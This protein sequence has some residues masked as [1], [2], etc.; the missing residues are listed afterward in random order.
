MN[1]VS[2]QVQLDKMVCSLF[3]QAKNVVEIRKRGQGKGTQK[4]HG[5]LNRVLRNMAHWEN[6]RE[7]M[8]EKLNKLNITKPKTKLK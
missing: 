6:D 1:R 8:Q 5:E 3:L 4:K 2:E 7:P